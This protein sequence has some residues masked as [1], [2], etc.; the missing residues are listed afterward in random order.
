MSCLNWTCYKVDCACPL[1]SKNEPLKWVNQCRY[2]GVYF[3]SGHSFICSFDQSKK[4]YF[5][6]LNSIFSKVG[7]LASEEVVV[8]LLR[9]KCLPVLL[10]GVEAC[11]VLVRDKQSL[12]FTISRSLMKLFR[13]GSANVIIDC[14]KQFQ[15]LPVSYLI[16]I[17]TT[18][19]LEKFTSSENLICSFL[20]NRSQKT[21]KNI[22]IKSSPVSS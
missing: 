20:P 7:R 14:Q 13:T 15:C 9:G 4:Q 11:P 8:S 18:K 6:A 3:V 22:L 12:E 2:L 1:L 21:Y 17:R 5:K 19:F 10:Y 16:D